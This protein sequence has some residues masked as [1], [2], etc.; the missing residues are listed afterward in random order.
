MTDHVDD[1]LDPG[2][3]WS[4]RMQDRLTGLSPELTEL[5]LH[6]GTSAD[7]W[8][9]RYKVDVAWKRRTKVLLKVGGAGELV[10]AARSL[11]WEYEIPDGLGF[12]PL[13]PGSASTSLPTT[14]R[15]RLRPQKTR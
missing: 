4:R 8:N 13:G 6:L 12:R 9:H 3:D 1:L 7:F 14:A 11:D 10:R 15:V 5:V 2:N